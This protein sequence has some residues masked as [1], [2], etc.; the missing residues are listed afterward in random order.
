ME[1]TRHTGF[2]LIELLLALALIAVLTGVAAPAMGRL[3]DLSRLRSAAET[4][5]Q[6]L[7]QARNHALSQQR[8]TY[9]SF[10]AASDSWCYGWRDSSP[11][12]CRSG[13][14]TRRCGVDRDGKLPSHRQSSIEFPNV[15]L[16][17]TRSAKAAT[18]HFSPYRGAAKALSLALH[19]RAGELRVIVSPLGRIRICSPE[20]RRYPPC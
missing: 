1:D 3:L 9:F 14:V 16:A 11:C 18:L 15:T 12:D 20:A 13:D 17:S 7:Q 8:I 4:L 6:E 2:T 5:F 10:F 19:N